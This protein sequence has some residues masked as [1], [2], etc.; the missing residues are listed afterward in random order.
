MGARWEEVRC[1][2]LRLAKRRNCRSTEFTP[3]TPCDWAPQ[4]VLDP[5]FEMYFTPEGAWSYIIELLES[6]LEFTP[7]PMTRPPDTIAYE[8]LID[9]GPNRPA[10]Y[11]K[12]QIY[13]GR[14]LGRSFHNSVK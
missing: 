9:C 13:K 6:G 2:L 4:S 1:E 14:V 3:A 5:R 8:T 10:L 12:L 11:I 7:V